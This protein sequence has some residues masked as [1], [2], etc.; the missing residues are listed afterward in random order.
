MGL[1]ARTLSSETE[2]HYRELRPSKRRLAGGELNDGTATT[3][4]RRSAAQRSGA[5]PDSRQRT[6]LACSGRGT[7]VTRTS[8]SAVLLFG[9]PINHLLHLVVSLVC[10]G[11]WIPV[12]F[13]LTVFGGQKREVVTIDPACRRWSWLAPTVPAPDQ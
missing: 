12:W 13:A 6:H 3:A 9:K 8:T 5:F 7:V 2:T 11:F 1:F 4:I 10:C